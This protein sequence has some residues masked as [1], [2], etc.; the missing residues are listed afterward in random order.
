MKSTR[1]LLFFMISLHYDIV[2]VSS[3][4]R[5]ILPSCNELNFNIIGRDEFIPKYASIPAVFY[6]TIGKNFCEWLYVVL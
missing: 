1:C 2:T 3:S 5:Q 4:E 6:A